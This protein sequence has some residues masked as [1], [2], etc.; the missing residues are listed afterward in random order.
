LEEKF[1]NFSKEIKNREIVEKIYS[2]MK[3][4]LENQY[5]VTKII[6]EFSEVTFHSFKKI[7]IPNNETTLVFC[8]SSVSPLNTGS[9][10][11]DSFNSKS[12]LENS[13]DKPKNKKYKK[14]ENSD[15]C[16]MRIKFYYCEETSKYKIC[17]LS[18][19]S[20][21]HSPNCDDEKVIFFILF[22]S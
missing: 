2:K 7:N 15:P 10:D 22:I 18:I 13:I 9:F 21:N 1:F 8:C 12:T 11:Y 14:R 17:L 6:Q 3:Q 20:H 4:P 19:F 5:E 16:P